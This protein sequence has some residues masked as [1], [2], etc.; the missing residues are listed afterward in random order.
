MFSW[1]DFTVKFPLIMP[2]V[3][4]VVRLGELQGTTP[5]VIKMFSDFRGGRVYWCGL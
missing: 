3:E 2:L 4:C 5:R 1:N